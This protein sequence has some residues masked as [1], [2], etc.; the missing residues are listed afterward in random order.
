[1]SG[2]ENMEHG[3]KISCAFEAYDKEKKAA[4][5]EFIKTTVD[6]AMKRK[7]HRRDV[8]WNIYMTKIK[9]ARQEE[10]NHDKRSEQS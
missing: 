2:F 7:D 4:E 10:K 5:K 6:E 1:M 3:R 9:E 8:A